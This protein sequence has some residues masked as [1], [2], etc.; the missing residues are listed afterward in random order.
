MYYSFTIPA[1]VRR[2]SIASTSNHVNDPSSTPTSTL[3][4]YVISFMRY[5]L[6]QVAEEEELLTTMHGHVLLSCIGCQIG[7]SVIRR[8]THTQMRATVVPGM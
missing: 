6:F 2:Q 3:A 7:P 5:S 4:S 1:T 8:S